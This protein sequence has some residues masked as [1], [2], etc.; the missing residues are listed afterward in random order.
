MPTTSA[1]IPSLEDTIQDIELEEQIFGELVEENSPELNL[2]Q[3]EFDTPQS[4][5]PPS[6]PG[7]PEPGNQFWAP[8]CENLREHHQDPESFATALVRYLNRR[9]CPSSLPPA[10]PP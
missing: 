7:T 1:I 3:A 8:Y 6:T 10:Y 5:S 2:D 4:F 9:F